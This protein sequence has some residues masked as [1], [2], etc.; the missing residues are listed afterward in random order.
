MDETISFEVNKYTCNFSMGTRL[1]NVCSKCKVS[2][3][4]WRVTSVVGVYWK[5]SLLE[6]SFG[7]L[8]EWHGFFYGFGDKSAQ[9]GQLAI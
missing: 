2:F 7:N 3:N 5:I 1:A 9:S 6:A 4:C 8:E